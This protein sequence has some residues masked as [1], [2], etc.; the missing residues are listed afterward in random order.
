MPKALNAET[1][2][3]FF[4]S[5]AISSVRLSTTVASKSFRHLL[6]MPFGL[7]FVFFYFFSLPKVGAGD[8]LAPVWSLVY[9]TNWW[10]YPFRL[11]KLLSRDAMQITVVSLHELF[12]EIN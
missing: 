11:D 4:Y 5:R 1:S 2:I 12:S 10:L 6:S 9:G 3:G 8:G 7:L